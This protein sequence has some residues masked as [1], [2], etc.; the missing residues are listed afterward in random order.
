MIVRQRG[1]KSS[2]SL[3]VLP[4]IEQQRPQAPRSLT[5]EERAVWRDLVDRVRPDWFL[6][7]EH[8][9][10]I[11]VRSICMERFLAAQIKETTDEKR[12]LALSQMRKAEGMLIGNLA[13]KLR[14]SPRS[15]KDRYAPKLV[16]PRGLPKPWELG[17]RSPFD[18]EPPPAA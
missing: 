12:L 8:L 18:D 3:S 14:L 16:R 4:A 13:G 11:Y 10:E 1:P 17:Q 6:G 7:A 15:T 9:L 2:A 5:R